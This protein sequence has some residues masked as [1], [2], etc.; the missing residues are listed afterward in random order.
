MI[1]VTILNGGILYFKTA[2]KIRQLLELLLKEIKVRNGQR[3]GRKD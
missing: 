3:K 2:A 1:S